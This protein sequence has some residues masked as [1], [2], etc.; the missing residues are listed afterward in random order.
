MEYFLRLYFN[1]FN[2]KFSIRTFSSKEISPV[3]YSSILNDARRDLAQYFD[4]YIASKKSNFYKD[5]D[6]IF[7]LMSSGHGG[8]QEP[9][10]RY[11]F[12]RL[13][14]DQTTYPDNSREWHQAIRFYLRTFQTER[15]C[16]SQ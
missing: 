3:Y 9:F 12:K 1:F 11:H 8:A 2:R 6:R 4:R 10:L 5:N 14:D 15:C 13:M 16:T 7:V